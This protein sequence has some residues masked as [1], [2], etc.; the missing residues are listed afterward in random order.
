MTPSQKTRNG[1]KM[2]RLA[3]KRLAR[4]GIL[5]AGHYVGDFMLRAGIRSG[6]K[7]Y[8]EDRWDERYSQACDLLVY[9]DRRS[10]ILGGYKRSD[11]GEW[12]TVGAQH[13]I[14]EPSPASSKKTCMVI[15]CVI[16]TIKADRDNDILEPEGAKINQPNAVALATHSEH[17]RRSIDGGCRA[18]PKED[19]RCVRHSR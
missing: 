13:G 12:V 14:K 6:V 5:T 4:D 17:A 2:L 8:G 3:R 1:R 7:A 15:E 16:T 19:Q 18:E 9:T 10:Q 11:T